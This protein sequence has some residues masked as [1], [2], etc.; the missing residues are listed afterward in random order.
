LHKKLNLETKVCENCYRSFAWRKK[1]E[2]DWDEIKF[3]SK[4]CKAESKKTQLMLELDR[5]NTILFSKGI[6][7]YYG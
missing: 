5:F 7:N 6:N 1:W 4:K 2:R 3:C